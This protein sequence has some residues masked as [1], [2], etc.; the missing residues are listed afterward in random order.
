MIETERADSGSN[1]WE[2][3]SFIL[4]KMGICQAELTIGEIKRTFSLSGSPSA[5]LERVWHAEHSIGEQA[6]LR[7]C[8]DRENFSENH[9]SLIADIAAEA[10][11]KAALRWKEMNDCS[12]DFESEA[13]ESTNYQQQKARSLYRPTYS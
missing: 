5:D 7:V 4:K 12:L 2:D 8:A 3:Y 11:S 1:L 13:G 10:W 9:F 6:T